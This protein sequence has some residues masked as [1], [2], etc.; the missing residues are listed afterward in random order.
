MEFHND[1]S[2]DSLLA[3][4]VTVYINDGSPTLSSCDDCRVVARDGALHIDF[5]P[6]FN[7]KHTSLLPETAMISQ[8]E[9]GKHAVFVTPDTDAAIHLQ[10]LWKAQKVEISRRN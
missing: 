6:R 1:S 4:N 2:E 5:I 10:K 3:A 8:D 7:G 9:T